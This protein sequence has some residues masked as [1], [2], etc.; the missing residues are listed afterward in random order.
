MRRIR[1][2]LFI[3]AL[4]LL[5]ST[6]VFGAFFENGVK[7]DES[8]TYPTSFER[9]DPSLF[10]MPLDIVKGKTF[11]KAVSREE[12]SKTITVYHYG[13]GT[14]D[15]YN[16]YWW[17]E[18]SSPPQWIEVGMETSDDWKY[19][20]ITVPNLPV[21]VYFDSWQAS[22]DDNDGDLYWISDI[23]LG[24]GNKCWVYDG[25]IYSTNPN[26]N[27]DYAWFSKS[28][29]WYAY[30]VWGDQII[31]LGP[32]L[33]E[34]RDNVNFY[35][36]PDG[37][38][39]EP[40]LKYKFDDVI[41]SWDPEKAYLKVVDAKFRL[42]SGYGIE[43]YYIQEG[44]IRGLVFDVDNNKI[45][46]GDNIANLTA[47][48]PGNPSF[49]PEI[50]GIRSSLLDAKTMVLKGY[51]QGVI[52][53]ITMDYQGYI[54]ST[55]SVSQRV[56]I[57]LGGVTFTADFI[58]VDQCGYY[59][60]SGS[61]TCSAGSFVFND[62]EIYYNA[63]AHRL[64][65]LSGTL[66]VGVAEIT[67]KDLVIDSNTGLVV[68]GGATLKIPEIVLGETRLTNIVADFSWT[69]FHCRGRLENPAGMVY[70]EFD[71]STD[72]AVSNITTAGETSLSFGN[73]VISAQWFADFG[74]GTYSAGGNVSIEGI[75]FNFES[76]TFTYN[77]QEHTVTL[78]SGEI[79]FPNT[80]F[81]SVK[82]VVYNIDTHEIVAGQLTVGVEEFQLG[83]GRAA[84]LIGDFYK[85]HLHLFGR[86]ND[87]IGVAF[88]LNFDLSYDGVVS[89]VMIGAQLQSIQIGNLIISADAYICPSAG[90]YIFNGNVQISGYGFTF[91]QL[92]I[93]HNSLE[94]TIFI[95][96]AELR[97]PYFTGTV[98]GVL[99]NA[100]TG[101]II[102]GAGKVTLGQFKIGN[103]DIF[104]ISASFDKNYLEVDGSIGLSELVG[105]INGIRVHFKIDWKGNIYSIGGGVTGQIPILDT[106]ISL[107][108][109]YIEVDNELG[110]IEDNG[111]NRTG[112]VI[113]LVG[114]IAPTGVGTNTIAED[115][116]LIIEPCD[117]RFTGNGILKVAGGEVANTT[118]MI[119]PKHLK[120]NANST[121]RIGGDEDF[122]IHGDA[123]LE[124]WWESMLLRRGAG[125]GYIAYKSHK[126]VNSDFT[127][128]DEKLYGQA[129]VTILEDWLDFC[130]TYEF[131]ND[132]NLNLMWG[133]SQL[134]VITDPCG[135]NDQLPSCPTDLFAATGSGVVEIYWNPA[136]DDGG[137]SYYR[138][139]K[140]GSPYGLVHFSSGKFTDTN[141]V[142]GQIYTYEIHAI[143]SVYQEQTACKN[144]SI[145]AGNSNILLFLTSQNGN[146]NLNWS[147]WTLPE[148]IIYKGSDP[149]HL[150]EFSRTSG[151]TTFDDA[152]S[153]GPLVFYTVQQRDIK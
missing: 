99:I 40:V 97:L 123:W 6:F 17:N 49:T 14:L 108:N 116:T 23:D 36:S 55:Q 148:Y 128:D 13:S 54:T 107:Y 34:F 39:W 42:P 4:T 147:G 58:E 57:T 95:S 70:V 93:T 32:N 133:C 115:F 68:I 141:V 136:L 35:G 33:Y 94:H 112:W 24:E 127:L 16:L 50:S 69:G 137:I 80:F 64:T 111:L 59:H 131:Y 120:A 66:N 135:R 122:E 25:F 21:Y 138:I 110:F 151:T 3:F 118:I 75:D 15:P 9:K 88:Q 119:E 109:P 117:K 130:L 26:A 82:D 101:E 81:A 149:V 5:V 113:I 71:L 47:F 134:P 52:K 61:I 84:G 74:N 140:N 100:D 103:Y 129:Q 90:V 67:I 73:S 65:L 102:D 98:N 144:I 41:V 139:Y 153:G 152:N 76:L 19:A 31:P 145:K 146:I 60:L 89:N 92:Q 20:T 132:G 22:C 63:E 87:P 62:L 53:Q 8:K 48:T 91:N 18:S 105:T 106:G 44:R 104:C 46:V 45:V 143:D 10:K 86:Y 30:T 114:T 1:I 96:Y 142:D 83:N 11:N 51:E 12:T 150:I 29:Y 77:D 27:Q 37:N 28:Y 125:N 121:I 56:S 124:Y 2:S 78:K 79:K 7:R 85:D 126:V 72:G 38:S 43:N